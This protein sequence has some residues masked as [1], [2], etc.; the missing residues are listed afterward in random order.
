MLTSCRGLVRQNVQVRVSSSR[1][2]AVLLLRFVVKGSARRG[3]RTGQADKD[4]Q[5]LA[6]CRVQRA[7]ACM[8]R[9]V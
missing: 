6:G 1:S 4:E 8:Y 9:A 5:D 3:E 7:S 2:E